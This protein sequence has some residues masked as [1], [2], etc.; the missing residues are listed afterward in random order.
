M[1][2]FYLSYFLF[3]L[4]SKFVVTYILSLGLKKRVIISRRNLF[5]GDIFIYSY[6]F[7]IRIVMR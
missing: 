6:E 2:L 4:R 7:V 3:N 5:E 1:R